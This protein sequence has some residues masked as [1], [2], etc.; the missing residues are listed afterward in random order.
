MEEEDFVLKNLSEADDRQG[1]VYQYDLAEIPVPIE[2]SSIEFN[3]TILLTYF[4]TKLLTDILTLMLILF[5]YNIVWLYLLK[6]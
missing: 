2:I 6:K 3:E 5:G 1:V 4:L